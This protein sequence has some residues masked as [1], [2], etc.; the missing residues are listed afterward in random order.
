[1]LVCSL[2]VTLSVQTRY[3]TTK[4][5]NHMRATILLI[6][7]LTAPGIMA[8][9]QHIGL[10]DQAPTSGGVQVV[11]ETVYFH[12]RSNDGIFYLSANDG[13]TWTPVQFADAGASFHFER[14]GNMEF[15]SVGS[16]EAGA[17]K[18]L[19][20]AIGSEEWG[21]AQGVVTDFRIMASGRIVASV[22]EDGLSGI[23]ISD[24]Q[25][26]NWYPAYPPSGTVQARL[27]GSDA[28]GRP[29][30]QTFQEVDGEVVNLQMLFSPNA[31]SEW[32][33]LSELEHDASWATVSSDH[34]LYASNGLRILRSIEDGE[35]WEVLSVDF[36]YATLTGS[37]LFNM[38]GGHLYF[39]CHEEGVTPN[40]N[41]YQSFDRGGSWEPVHDPISRLLI[42]NM[43]RSMKGVL[44]ASTSNGV[45]RLEAASATSVAEVAPVVEVQAY[46]VPARD[47]LR[48]SVAN[49]MITE[50]RVYDASSREVMVLPQVD[51]PVKT[52]RVGH[53]P[54]GVYV[55]RAVTNKGVA[56]TSVVVE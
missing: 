43:A 53:L 45:Y 55:V 14:H 54:A 41:F 42:F 38:G 21:A 51:R 47:E 48:L 50:L 56:I 5:Q 25:G 10:A 4:S 2:L 15:L 23:A 52:I 13:A 3:R 34:S 12:P 20:H 6:G 7:T 9:W 24:D 18:L 32:K 29:L 40:G 37:R 28:V 17:F 26:D 49:A 33:P 36:P 46:P 39:M 11:D 35:E 31:G 16:P 27:V 44:Y 8:Q 19:R 22:V 1:M 30:I